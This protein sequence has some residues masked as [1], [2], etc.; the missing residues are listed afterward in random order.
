MAEPESARRGPGQLES[1]VLAALWAAEEPLV[2]GDVQRRLADGGLDLA[3]T[4]VTTTLSRLQ[5]KGQLR[6]HA[7]G[8]AFAYEPTAYAADTAARRMMSLLGSGPARGEVLSRFVA[9]L[10]PE[11]EAVLGE[12]LARTQ[13]SSLSE[14]QP[15]EGGQADVHGDP[16]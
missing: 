14:G 7:R 3:Y 8:R 13:P 1:A 16:S 4:S 10:T 15:A 2:P 5:A 11:D 12:L 6:R 9:G